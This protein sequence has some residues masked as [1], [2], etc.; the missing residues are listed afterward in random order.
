MGNGESDSK[1]SAC[2]VGDPGSIPML[3]RS[4]GKGNGNPLQYSC[5]EN[6]MDRGARWAMVHGVTKSG[7]WL[8]QLRMHASDLT[9]SSM[10]K[11]SPGKQ[12]LLLL[13]SRFSRV[14][15]CATPQM[16]AHQAP[17]SLGFSRQEHRS[18]L[19]F[20]SLMHEGSIPWV[21]KIPSNRKQQPTPAFLHGRSTDRRATV[22][23]ATKN[24]TQLSWLTHT[25]LKFISNTRRCILYQE[26]RLIVILWYMLKTLPKILGIKMQVD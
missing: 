8:K 6:P 25:R 1:E 2:T 17:P 20:P 24:Q 19:P 21:G 10:V 22:C 26:K 11:S 5:L 9:G 13:L 18:G 12:E 3:G 14:W 23:G 7:T 4:S 15:L 16:A